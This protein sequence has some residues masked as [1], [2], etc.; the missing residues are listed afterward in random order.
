M[1]IKEIRQ[2][3]IG[4]L[5]EMKQPRDNVEAIVTM[6]KSE[7]QMLTMIDWIQKHHK[8]NPSNYRVIMTAVN[9]KQGVK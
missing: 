4:D 9:I 2:V 7:D 1:T 8:E 6:L 5:F 3:L